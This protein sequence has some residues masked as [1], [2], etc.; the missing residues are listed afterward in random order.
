MQKS[1]I[2]TTEFWVALAGALLP[3]LSKAFGWDLPNEAI[4]TLVAY[5]VGRSGLKAIE[6]RRSQ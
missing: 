3:I 6:S 1:G 2:K 4:A 5:I